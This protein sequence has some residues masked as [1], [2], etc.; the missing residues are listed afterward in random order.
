MI[1]PK[2]IPTGQT[3]LGH[4]ASAKRRGEM[5]DQEFNLANADWA[6]KNVSQQA[7][8]PYPEMPPP[9]R[10]YVRDRLSGR[11][12]YNPTYAGA[13][14]LWISQIVAAAGENQARMELGL[15]WS[16]QKL[17]EAGLKHN[18]RA[19]DQMLERHMQNPL[20]RQD[21]EDGLRVKEM[22]S[23]DRKSTRVIEKG[24]RPLG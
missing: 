6:A 1:I 8:L 20:P 14:G 13:L 23:R 3:Y 18:L 2:D 15:L 16:K 24:L 21:I 4:V 11:G 9:V 19:I 12:S 22:D 10:N 7:P 5:T 17:E